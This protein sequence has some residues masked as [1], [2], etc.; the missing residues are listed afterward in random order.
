MD[1]SDSESI[2]FFGETLTENDWITLMGSYTGTRLHGF[3]RKVFGETLQGRATPAGQV[4]CLKTCSG[5][6]WALCRQIPTEQAC[7][8]HWV[9]GLSFQQAHLQTTPRT[10][11]DPLLIMCSERFF[12]GAKRGEGE[13]GASHGSHRNRD[14]IHRAESWRPCPAPTGRVTG[15]ELGRKFLERPVLDRRVKRS[16]PPRSPHNG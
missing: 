5:S 2:S 14:W 13:G 7:R 9:G 6:P 8:A 16:H 12:V 11:R 15:T 3:K 10:R 4:S 1:Q